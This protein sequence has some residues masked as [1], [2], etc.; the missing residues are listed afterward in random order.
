VVPC[1]RKKYFGN[2]PISIQITFQMLA[3]FPKKRFDWS[4]ASQCDILE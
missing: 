4:W 1:N 3:T 2:N